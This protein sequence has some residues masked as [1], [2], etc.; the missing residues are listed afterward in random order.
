ML[1]Y[2]PHCSEAYTFQALQLTPLS[3]W[4]EGLACT[5]ADGQGVGSR[6]INPSS[7]LGYLCD[8]ATSHVP[9]AKWCSVLEVS[10]STAFL[11]V[12]CTEKCRGSGA[13]RL[14]AQLPCRDCWKL[15]SVC[16]SLAV[17]PLQHASFAAAFTH[18]AFTLI[19]LL[20]LI[21]ERFCLFFFLL[22]DFF[23][24]QMCTGNSE[25]LSWQ[26]WNCSYLWGVSLVG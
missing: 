3:H 8:P 19:K 1:V 4:I 15:P 6:I 11:L 14:T 18:A 25:V 24:N 26:L 23:F 7:S 22:W 12:G 13:K 9:S 5:K 21:P 17:V 20:C 10:L 2:L 16:C